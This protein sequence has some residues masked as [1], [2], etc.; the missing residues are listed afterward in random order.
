M[1]YRSKGF[2]F[3]FMV[4]QQGEVAQIYALRRVIVSFVVKAL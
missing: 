3:I 2:V 4:N 1:I